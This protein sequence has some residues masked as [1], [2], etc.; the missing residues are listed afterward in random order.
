MVPLEVASKITERFTA[1]GEMNLQGPSNYFTIEPVLGA[2]IR[3][4]LARVTQLRL[5]LTFATAADVLS[6]NPKSLGKKGFRLR[7]SRYIFIM[8]EINFNAEQNTC[9]FKQASKPLRN[10]YMT[11]L[12]LKMYSSPAYL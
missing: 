1:L 3:M 8:N 10:T 2:P 6:I 7:T 12:S 4:V 11:L 9:L 5:F